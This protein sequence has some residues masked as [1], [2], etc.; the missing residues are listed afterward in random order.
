ML[1]DK[2]ISSQT[3]SINKRKTKKDFE[4]VCQ[5]FG[6]LHAANMPSSQKRLLNFLLH[7]WQ[8]KPTNVKNHVK[9]TCTWKS[10]T[11]AHSLLILTWDFNVPSLVPSFKH[12]AFRNNR[13]H[14]RGES[15]MNAEMK[16][17]KQTILFFDNITLIQATL[18]KHF[19]CLF[20]TMLYLY[21]KTD[22]YNYYYYGNDYYH[23]SWAYIGR[24]ITLNFIGTYSQTYNITNEEIFSLHI[25]TLQLN[26]TI[27]FNRILQY[28]YSKWYLL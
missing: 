7:F 18:L 6:L 19:Y 22:Y 8:S 1:Y 20:S 24:F 2:T 3:Q 5:I 23:E 10:I 9:R 26:V 11:E 16:C 12:R 27:I 25:S 21:L 17:S 4:Y 13:L 15:R 14:E 28:T